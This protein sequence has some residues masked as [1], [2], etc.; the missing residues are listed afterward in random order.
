VTDRVRLGLD[1]LYS[2][3]ENLRLSA[4]DGGPPDAVLDGVLVQAEDLKDAIREYWQT[5]D[6]YV[7]DEI[8]PGG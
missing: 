5:V 3:L 2:A 8:E 1:L 6:F 7:I 4:S